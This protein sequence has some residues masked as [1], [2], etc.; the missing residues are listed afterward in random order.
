MIYYRPRKC[1]IF[2]DIS[3]THILHNFPRL[4]SSFHSFAYH[5]RCNYEGDARLKELQKCRTHPRHETHLRTIFLKT[6]CTRKLNKNAVSIILRGGHFNV[7]IF[8]SE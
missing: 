5:H 7:V 1:A 6:E 8:W 2:T 4:S 3:L